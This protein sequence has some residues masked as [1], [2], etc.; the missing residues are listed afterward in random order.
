[1][2]NADIHVGDWSE[3]IPSHDINPDG[4]IKL[5]TKGSVTIF[6]KTLSKVFSS[7]KASPGLVF[8]KSVVSCRK[9]SAG[10][11]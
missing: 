1:M 4:K 8:F 2:V 5:K 9:E 3:K 6:I 7:I 11:P 10:F